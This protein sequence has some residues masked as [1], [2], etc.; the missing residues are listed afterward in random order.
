VVQSARERRKLGANRQRQRSPSRSKLW[1]RTLRGL[2]QKVK[3]VSDFFQ[4]LAISSSPSR[5]FVGSRLCVILS[6]AFRR[7]W[8]SGTCSVI[9]RLSLSNDSAD[10]LQAD[11]SSF[12][13]HTYF[14]PGS[15]STT[16]SPEISALRTSARHVNI[17]IRD[18]PWSCA[19]L[20][21][22][23]WSCAWLSDAPWSWAHCGSA[24]SRLSSL[25]SRVSRLGA[26]LQ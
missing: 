18:A 6:M 3:G 17:L 5:G 14:W 11:T 22:A 9:S 19:K 1:R 7:F 25:P 24:L 12:F 10:Q 23:P 16:R 15:G 26:T 8:P 2:H 4:N 20:S 13:S 21:E